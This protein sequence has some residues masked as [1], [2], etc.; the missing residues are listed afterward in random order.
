MKNAKTLKELIEYEKLLASLQIEYENKLHENSMSENQRKRLI[1]VT[2][3]IQEER[4]K[5][6]TMKYKPI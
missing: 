1:V 6:N 2:N 4:N 5:I 3:L